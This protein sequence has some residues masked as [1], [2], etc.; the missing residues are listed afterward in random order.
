MIYH[1]EPPENTEYI[2]SFPFDKTKVTTSGTNALMTP[3]FV[4]E[5]DD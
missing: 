1:H 4:V 2:D 3:S 5:R